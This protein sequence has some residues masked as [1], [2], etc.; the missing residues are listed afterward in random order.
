MPTKPDI[1]S[2]QVVELASGLNRK[3]RYR[4]V[5][6][7]LR[8]LNAE[9]LDQLS[10]VL[11]NILTDAISEEELRAIMSAMRAQ[12]AAG[13]GS[14]RESG[15]KTQKKMVRKRKGFLPLYGHGFG[16]E[17]VR[18]PRKRINRSNQQQWGRY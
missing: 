4:V 13:L 18:N 3:A 15:M 12:M 14:E 1:T 16:H 11:D 5:L 8:T 9:Q 7:L 10:Q 6:R 17:R 2:D